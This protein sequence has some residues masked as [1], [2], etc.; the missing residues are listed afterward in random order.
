[1]KSNL[2][3]SARNRVCGDGERTIESRT[4]KT[5]ARIK[6]FNSWFCPCGQRAWVCLEVIKDKCGVDY[7]FIPI[8]PYFVDPDGSETKTPL[9]LEEKARQ[10]PD[11]VSASPRGV[12]PAIRD[13]E[14]MVNDSSVV[15]EYLADAFPEAEL[16]PATP[17]E[18][19]KCRMFW[20]H[21]A[22][23]ILP[24]FYKI[25]M[26]EDAQRDYA[27]LDFFQGLRRADKMLSDMSPSGFFLGQERFSVAD[28]ALAPWVQRIGP[29]LGAYRGLDFPSGPEYTRFLSW[30]EALENFGPWKKCLVEDERLTRNYIGYARGKASNEMVKTVVEGNGKV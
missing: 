17:I 26:F 15:C 16:L 2:P 28:L 13:G 6:F 10:Y 30:W 22:S 21:C 3:L 24:H 9:P 23:Q 19:A 18:R 20:E 4:G 25:L 27:T 1:M 14:N 5:D 8:E 7:E 12:V 11:F 29:V